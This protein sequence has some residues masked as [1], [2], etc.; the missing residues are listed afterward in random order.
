[1]SPEDRA[2]ISPE[3]LARVHDKATAD[4]WTLGFVITFRG[5]GEVIGACGFKGPPSPDG[6]VEIAYGISDEY[7]GRGY[8]TEAAEALVRYAIESGEVRLVIAHTL[9]D[10]KASH[11]VLIKCGFEF[12]GEVTDPEDGLVWRWL[13]TI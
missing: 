5:T 13:K 9:P 2:E 10:N 12:A 7:R 11:R 3:W 8:A 1:M 6:I 4:V